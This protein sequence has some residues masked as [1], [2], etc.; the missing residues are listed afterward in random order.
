MNWIKGKR[1]YIIGFG[2]ILISVILL[3]T[4]LSINQIPDFVWVLLNGAGLAALRAGITFMSKNDNKGWK[5]YGAAI[6]LTV[7][8]LLKMFTG[9]E[10]PPEVML[11]FD[12]LGIVGLR[13]A[14]EKIN[15]VKK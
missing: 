8:G 4:K 13:Q 6:G 9:I 2:I 3:V 5:S 14:I 15:T 12:G 10:A 7:C 11:A 1:T